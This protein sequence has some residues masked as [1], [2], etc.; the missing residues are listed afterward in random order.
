[1]IIDPE[2]QA[3][4]LTCISIIIHKTYFDSVIIF[5]GLKNGSQVNAC[6]IYVLFFSQNQEDYIG[7][8][9]FENVPIALSDFSLYAYGALEDLC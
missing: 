1:M 6:Y 7:N 9:Y 5:L 3:T 2:Q 8:L 4:C